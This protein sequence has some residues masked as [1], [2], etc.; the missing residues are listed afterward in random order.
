MD[1]EFFPEDTVPGEFGAYGNYLAMRLGLSRIAPLNPIHLH[2]VDFN[3]A[4][5]SKW[6][7]RRINF[8]S[9]VFC[10][11]YCTKMWQ[12]NA[13]HS[14]VRHT[15]MCYF[16]LIIVKVWHSGCR[17]KADVTDLCLESMLA[18]CIDK[19]F[20]HRAGQKQRDKFFCYFVSCC[21]FSSDPFCKFCLSVFSSCLSSFRLTFRICIQQN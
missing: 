21:L 17:R 3:L 2:C 1:M 16:C 13:S 12:N 18:H 14:P 20:V 9:S 11:T 6:V 5:W 19:A 8:H 4:L 15:V 7:Q 10:L